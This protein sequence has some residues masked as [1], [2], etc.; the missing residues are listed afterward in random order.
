MYII[1][2]CKAQRKRRNHRTCRSRENHSC[3][4]VIA[5]YSLM[6]PFLPQIL[7]LVDLAMNEIYQE[8]IHFDYAD[9]AFRF[10]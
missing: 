2:A 7:S 9:Y 8:S 4:F 3:K 5:L 10:S 1:V 6:M